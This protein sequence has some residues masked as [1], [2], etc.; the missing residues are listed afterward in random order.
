M[1]AIDV[2]RGGKSIVFEHS[3][4]VLRLRERV[5]AKGFTFSF[6]FNIEDVKYPCDLSAEE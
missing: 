2:R 3:K 1:N 4:L 5:L 6:Y